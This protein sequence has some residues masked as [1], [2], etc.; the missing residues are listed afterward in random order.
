MRLLLKQI[1]ELGY[2]GVQ[3][4]PT[5]GLF[6]GRMRANLEETDLGYN[7][8]VEMIAIARELDLVTTPY[9]F[10]PEE[11][12]SM[13]KAGADIIVA[14]VG[15]TVGGT[16]GASSVIS[17]DDAVKTVQDIHDA[18]VAENSDVIVLCHGGP[19]AEPCDAEY[20]LQRTKGV[21]GFYGASSAERMPIEK[22]LTNH[23]NSFKSIKFSGGVK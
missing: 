23:I 11:A 9:A 4:F 17:L 3:N 1:K 12:V 10:T 14:H 21:H 6:E 2:S 19:I 13:V 22:A 8:E 18:S 16:I 15:C 5:V 20:V 7:K